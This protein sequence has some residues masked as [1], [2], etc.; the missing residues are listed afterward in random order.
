MPTLLIHNIRL[1]FDGLPGYVVI[2]TPTI[3]AISHGDATQNIIASADNV[4]D[5][6]GKFLLPGAIDIHVHFREPGLT[7]KATIAGESRAAIAGG[8]TS[9][10]DMPNVVPPTLTAA[11]IETKLDIAH[12]T[13]VANYGF[14]IGASA[15]NIDKIINADYS[16]IA[17]IKLFLGSSTGD[18]LLNNDADIER[19]F[20]NIPRGIAVVVHAEDN[21]VIARQRKIYTDLYGED[22]DVRYHSSIRP[23]EACVYATEHI[24]TLASR[25]GVHLHIAHV[26]TADEVTLF[27]PGNITDKQF[28]CEV[29]P[30]HL[31]WCVDDYASRGT[32]IKINPS[33]K[34]A[35]DRSALRQ[36]VRDSRIDI[37]ATDHAPH[38]LAEKQGGAI[39]AASGAPMI[40]FSVPAMLD[41]FDI[42]TVIRTMC[43]NPAQLLG[44]DKRGDIAPG[45]YADLILASSCPPYAVSD[46]DVI[47]ACKWTPLAP[48]STL[49]TTSQTP[50]YLKHQVQTISLNGNTPDTATAMPLKFVHIAKRHT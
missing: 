4:I 29:S 9:F 48:A 34:T 21:A 44:I 6:G 19:L 12:K 1:P 49:S 20:D 26:S 46:N 36:A 8:V 23:A 41:M 14:Y 43:H 10:V 24:M 45:Y 50:F 40:Q 22:P 47:S 39:T 3:S 35:A 2:D 7:H 33:V 18:L 13:A 15:S 5:G 32:R 38:T 11:D 31:L 27:S 17:G 16:H 37:I 30:H 42:K 28:T 25:Y